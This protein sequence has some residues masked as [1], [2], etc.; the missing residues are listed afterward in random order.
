MADVRSLLRQERAARQPPGR[1]QKQ[2]AA[3]AAAPT[4]KKRK[5]ANDEGEDRKRTRTE[6]EAEAGVPSGFFDG[7]AATDRDDASLASAPQAQQEAQT[8]P[9]AESNAPLE[10]PPTANP[11]T[12]RLNAAEQAE[13]EAFLSEMADEPTAQHGFSAYAAGAVIEAAPMTTAEIA[14]QARENQ[15]AQRA[16]KDEEMEGEKEDA[17]RLLED[18]FEEME[19]LEERFRKLREQRE[20]LRS[21]RAQAKTE[22]I[23]LPEVQPEPMESDSDDEEWDDWRFRAA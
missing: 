17:A 9:E 5:A 21:A 20:A 10:P 8:I 4:S 11:P 18:E 12:P 1:P 22:D 7:G 13:L 23:V 15:S 19:G 14:A 16:R 6:A 3:P 2:S